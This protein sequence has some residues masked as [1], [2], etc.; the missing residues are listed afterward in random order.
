MRNI[1]AF[2]GIGLQLAADK[3]EAKRLSLEAQAKAEQD[4][5]ACRVQVTQGVHAGQ[6]GVLQTWA[7]TDGL[8]AV[9]LSDGHVV[10][11][12]ASDLEKQAEAPVTGFDGLD[13]EHK[14]VA[15]DYGFVAAVRTPTSDE[16]AQSVIAKFIRTADLGRR[17]LGEQMLANRVA[18]AFA[19]VPDADFS[20][21]SIYA[22]VKLRMLGPNQTEVTAGNKT[23]FYSGE[24]V[25]GSIEAGAVTKTK[26]LSSPTVK[27][28]LEAW[29]AGRE[30]TAVD[31]AYLDKLGRMVEAAVKTE[32]VAA[33]ELAEAPWRTAEV[34]DGQAWHVVAE[35][36][37]CT[38]CM[39][40]Y[41]DAGRTDALSLDE[42]IQPIEVT[43]G[44]VCKDCHLP[45]KPAMAANL[46]AGEVA[47]YKVEDIGVEHTQYFAG[48][49]TAGTQWDAVFV[50][51]GRSYNAAVEDALE[52]AAASGYDVEGFAEEAKN[53]D[54]R[55]DEDAVQAYV[56]SMKPGE[57]EV[58]EEAG[59]DELQYHVALY[60]N[61]EGRLDAAQRILVAAP[62]KPM[63][64]RTRAVIQR[65]LAEKE[66]AAKKA[67]A[68][69]PT[70]MAPPAD[71]KKK[72]EEATAPKKP[73]VPPYK[74]V[75]KD[76][77]RK[78]KTG[79]A[80]HKM[81][82][83]K[84]GAVKEADVAGPLSVHEDKPGE[85]D[86][87]KLGKLKDAP[88]ELKE[89]VI[90]SLK[91]KELVSV[92]EKKLA[93]ASADIKK[94]EGY[95][96]EKHKASEEDAAIAELLESIDEEA[97]KMDDAILAL[98][99]GGLKPKYELT[100]EQKE[101]LR[102]MTKAQEAFVKECQ[103]L[104]D[105]EGRTT[106]TEER[107]PKLFTDPAKRKGEGAKGLPGA[108]TKKK[109]G[110]ESS[111]QAGITEELKKLLSKVKDMVKGLL[112]GMKSTTT[113]LENAA[114][115][116][117]DGDGLEDKAEPKKEKSEKKEDKKEEKAE[118]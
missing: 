11:V 30:A 97:V 43:E 39:L 77:F 63:S 107:S 98:I 3:K 16:E 59:D 27:R 61:G 36:P 83:E 109:A 67:P 51:I 35:G 32:V 41:A 101:K 8:V 102:E 2:L 25:V 13:A 91:R 64:E 105:K 71:L 95:D 104:S 65:A 54:P 21:L 31:Q 23:L 117:E 57:S 4:P 22:A 33:E 10:K 40:E 115:T 76:E 78:A 70:T 96:E 50:G 86:E 5:H 100:E 111:L 69:A 99:R 44:M 9:L 26:D 73:S 38:A 106:F 74:G 75:Q 113:I 19:L 85:V 82:H 89:L 45:I 28:H 52:L 103:E 79:E 29:L 110:V 53:K 24:T 62:P 55:A 6:T 56:S 60:L 12:V 93:D 7:S 108:D 17:A 46:K 48:R 80:A 116:P 1:S 68:A 92:I 118:E 58:V 112:S 18:L 114:A 15:L 87:T 37:V 81:K 66:A 34:G 84:P 42:D 90:S 14:Q 20:R 94:S 49:G 47:D 88:E 72:A